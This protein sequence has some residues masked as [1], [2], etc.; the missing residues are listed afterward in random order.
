M[1]RLK[2]IREL[3]PLTKGYRTT[4]FLNFFLVIISGIMK[5]STP[6]FVLQ[7]FDVAI[8]KLRFDSLI[9]YTMLIVITTA[10]GSIC[11]ILYQRNISKF[12]RTLVIKLRSRCFEHINK[13]SGNFMSNYNSGDLFTTMYRDIEEIPSI[14][15]TSLFNFVSNLIT[16]IGLAF[17]LITL[18][19][20]LLLILIAFQIILYLAQRFYNKKIEQVTISIRN[21][22]GKLNSSAQEMIGNLFSFSE[23]GLKE[24]FQKKHNKLETDYAKANIKGGY[25]IAL[26]HSVLNFINAV[27]I[28]V[29]LGYGGY[30]VIIGS[31]SYGGLVTFNLMHLL[32]RLWDCISGSITVD[33][34]DIK[35]FDI[36]CLRGQISIVSQNIF[37]LNDT[38]YNNI[39]LGKE[40]TDEELQHIL[41]QAGLHEFI[42]TLPN[43]LET[44]VGEN[45]IKL[46]GGEK[47]RISIARALLKK[48]PILIFD[49]ATSMLDNE[50]EEKIISI[51]L[52]S[53]KDTTIILIAH[54][55]STVKNANTIYVLNNGTIMEH[56]NHDQLLEQK[57][58]YYHLY[59]I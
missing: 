33:G 4:Y 44:V 3:F 23:G 42:N 5:I 1:K 14:L 38:I 31:L 16:V 55:L 54:R 10:I 53:F 30:K 15:T 21:A 24:F 7:V 46:S 11:E 51:L 26:N 43:K 40:I 9:F 6:F 50:T 19:F 34:I 8:T 59:N 13:L 25:T 45:G 35:D 49:E 27:T 36:D 12:N 58:I 18:Q 20:D 57:G 39:V 52:D 2:L 22:I 17:F 37:L 32:F 41:V 47:Q 56:G 28:A 48:N 29:L